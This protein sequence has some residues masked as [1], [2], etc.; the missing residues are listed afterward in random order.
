MN[1]QSSDPMNLPFYTKLKLCHTPQTKVGV[2]TQV[3]IVILLLSRPPKTHANNFNIFHLVLLSLTNGLQLGTVRK[4]K[5]MKQ[6]TIVGV[7]VRGKQ[8]D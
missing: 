6:K 7:K 3:T 2:F 4:G 1:P 8:G 5:R